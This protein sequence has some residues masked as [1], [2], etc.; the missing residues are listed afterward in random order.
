MG[1]V[2]VGVPGRL[3]WAKW[4]GFGRV[5]GGEDDSSLGSVDDQLSSIRKAEPFGM[6]HSERSEES[7]GLSSCLKAALTR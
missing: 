1:K 6:C 5:R 2:C 4:G 3:R 7:V